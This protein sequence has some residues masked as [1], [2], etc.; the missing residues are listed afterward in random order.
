MEQG[1]FLVL[2]STRLYHTQV[3]T[4]DFQTSTYFQMKNTYL[5]MKMMNI[6]T[7]IVQEIKEHYINYYIKT[8]LFH[9]M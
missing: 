5:K 3:I 9:Q 7:N 2:R 4:I 6:H 1:Q 8:Y